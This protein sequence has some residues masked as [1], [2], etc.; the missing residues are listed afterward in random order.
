M[1]TAKPNLGEIIGATIITPDIEETIKPYIEIFEYHV[2]SNSIIS[3]QLADLWNTKAHL[4][5]ESKIIAPKNRTYPWI[6]F[7]QA[8]EIADYKAMTSYGWHSLEIN[9]QSVNEIPNKLANSNLKIIGEPHQ[10]G[11]SKSIRAMQVI[12]YAKEVL[13]LTEIPNDGSVN[14]LPIA[15]NFIDKIFIVPLGTSN[16]DETREWYLKN[17][18]NIKRGLEA[19]DIKMPLISNALAIDPNTKCSI[20]TIR[21][22]NK[23]S[24]EIDDYPDAAS[25][26]D[27]LPNSLPPGVSIVSFEVD[28]LDKVKVPFISEKSVI[29]DSPY[30]NS[31]VGVIRGSASEII[32]LVERK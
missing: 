16:M 20:C 8:I 18:P 32:E 26:R 17:F 24:I 27:F 4:K 11:M 9:V 3:D 2:I 29:M 1:D 14:H 15:E 5:S 10:L 21:L 23:S 25:K 12:G 28:S 7:I 30:S 22:P 6:R 31:R 13:Y 19:R